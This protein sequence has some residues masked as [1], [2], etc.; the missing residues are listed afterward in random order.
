MF[1]NL[2]TDTGNGDGLERVRFAKVKD[3]IF[4]YDNRENDFTVFTGL[5]SCY[6]NS[7]HATHN[8]EISNE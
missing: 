1:N 4:V 6:C 8:N 2:H 5:Y 7:T 3:G